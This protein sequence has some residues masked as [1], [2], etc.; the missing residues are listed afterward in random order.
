MKPMPDPSFARSSQADG[1]PSTTALLVA[2]QSAHRDL[3]GGIDALDGV[4]GATAP[5]P[6]ALSSARFRLGRASLARRLLSQRVRDHLAAQASGSDLQTIRS[7]QQ[8]DFDYVRTST[9]HIQRW[10]TAAA[11]ADWSG[12]REASLAM[13]AKLRAAIGAERRVL[14]PLLARHKDR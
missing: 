5:D 7:L 10:S 4:V 12:F 2:L 13:R 8:A 3:E 9:S 6:A 1:S 14:Y 11:L